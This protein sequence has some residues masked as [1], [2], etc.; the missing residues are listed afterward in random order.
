MGTLA[1]RRAGRTQLGPVKVRRAMLCR[2]LAERE[3]AR[4]AHL[5][6]KTPDNPRLHHDA[7][8]QTMRLTA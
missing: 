1:T 3:L 7:F 6:D 4:E 8:A 5:S 2:G